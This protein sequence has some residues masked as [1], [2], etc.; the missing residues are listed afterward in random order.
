MLNEN[1]TACK[2]KTQFPHFQVWIAFNLSPHSDSSRLQQCLVSRENHP[3][4]APSKASKVKVK[5]L[6]VLK[7]LTYAALQNPKTL[8]SSGSPSCFCKQTT[9]Y[10]QQNDPEDGW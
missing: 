1:S 9:L 2:V 5:P 4:T 7:L 3:A 10:C 6:K 8:K